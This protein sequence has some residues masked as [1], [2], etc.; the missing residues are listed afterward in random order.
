MGYKERIL[1]IVDSIDIG[2]SIFHVN[3]LLGTSIIAGESSFTVDVGTDTQEAAWVN[4][5][6][7]RIFNLKTKK[8]EINKQVLMAHVDN[9]IRNRSIMI[10]D[11]CS[12]YKEPRRTNVYK[13]FRNMVNELNPDKSNFDSIMNSLFDIMK[14]YDTQTDTNG[15][16]D[17]VHGKN[18]YN[19][20]CLMEKSCGETNSN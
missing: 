11:K 8:Y 1:E 2:E 4:K 16:I 6:A 20:L 14:Y 19:L 10:F 17:D 15:N 13:R 7:R 12:P 5:W 9:E 3:I 18:V